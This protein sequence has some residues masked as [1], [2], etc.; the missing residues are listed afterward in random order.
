MVGAVLECTVEVEGVR[1]PY[2][3]SIPA[4]GRIEAVPAKAIIP[5][6]KV[7]ALV[8]SNLPP[9]ANLAV[10][11]GSAAVNVVEVGNTF[12]CTISD[13][14]RTQTVKVRADDVKSAVSLQL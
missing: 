5:T 1:A 3:V 7:V 6:A 8:R 9:G 2:R 13:G 14:T 12:A 10:D 4:P 11:C